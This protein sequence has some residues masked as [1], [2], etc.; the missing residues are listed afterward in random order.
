MN[1]KLLKERIKTQAQ[2]PNLQVLAARR[3]GKK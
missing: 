3:K 2:R 1:P